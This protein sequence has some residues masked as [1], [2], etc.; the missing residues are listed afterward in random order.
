MQ[1][2]EENRVFKYSTLSEAREAEFLRLRQS[3]DLVNFSVHKNG[4]GKTTMQCRYFKE[5]E[6]AA[7]ISFEHTHIEEVIIKKLEE[8]FE[9]EEGKDFAYVRP[10]ELQ[11]ETYLSLRERKDEE[12]RKQIAIVKRLRDVGL[13]ARIIHDEI[14]HCNLDNCGYRRQEWAINKKNPDRIGRI[15]C[16]YKMY[17]NKEVEFLVKDLIVD[18][19]DAMMY[20]ERIYTDVVTLDEMAGYIG[21]DLIRFSD[22]PPGYLEITGKLV[23]K[24]YYLVEQFKILQEEWKEK[25][26]CG[27][28]PKDEEQMEIKLWQN[29]Y[30]IAID[31]YIPTENCQPEWQ[32]R[33]HD[34][35]YFLASPI[36]YRILNSL[37]SNPGALKKD[38]KIILSMARARKNPILQRRFTQILETIIN[39]EMQGNTGRDALPVSPY[40]DLNTSKLLP[41]FVGE[42][43]PFPD[44][45]WALNVIKPISRLN[46]TSVRDAF[47]KEN[48]FRKAP[49]EFLKLNE[50]IDPITTKHHNQHGLVITFHG[51]VRWIEKMEKL[52]SDEDDVKR[53]LMKYHSEETANEVMAALK[54]RK[55]TEYIRFKAFGNGSAG[56]EM[57]GN[58]RFLIVVGNW[59]NGEY[60]NFNGFFYPERGN[61]YRLTVNS[62]LGKDLKYKLQSLIMRDYMEYPLR[63][64]RKLPVYCVTNYFAEYDH[65]LQDINTEILEDYNVSIHTM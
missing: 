36:L 50:Q 30:R 19:I 8:E 43:I 4:F 56:T 12:A 21:D 32:Y 53:E 25:I 52:L 39:V 62:E 65:D 49:L 27:W 48:E 40:K 54:T 38:S 13:N 6:S 28:R 24:R 33:D 44:E 63:A 5:S 41:T 42:N 34:G 64:R 15:V 22:L 59:W 2:Y 16:T 47:K 10:F 57:R 45:P 51:I 37:S 3:P 46:V 55:L 35:E 60:N 31:G 20:P 1:S 11:C 58:E 17:L 7:Y 29:L 26:L 23:S 14:L 9:M 18:E 61:G